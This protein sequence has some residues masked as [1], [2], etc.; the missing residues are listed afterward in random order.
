M[1]RAGAG[2]DLMRISAIDIGTNT[3]LMLIAEMADGG[4][5]RVIRDEHVIARLGK[6][7]DENRRIPPDAFERVLNHL[8]EYKRIH[9]SEHSGAIIACGTSALRDALN[10]DEFIVFIRERL[11]I[12]I[13][14]LSGEEEAALTYLGAVSEFAESEP[15]KQIV[16]I[17]IGGG[18]TEFIVGQGDAIRSRVSLDVG[19]V[20]LTERFLKNSPPLP[21]GL[22]EAQQYIRERVG[23]L[24][25]LSGKTRCIGVAGTLTTLAALD[26]QLSV[27]DRSRVSGH[28]L[29]LEVI[30]SIFDQLKRK[31]LE[32]LKAIPQILPQRADIILAG[33]LILQEFMGHLGMDRITASDRGLRYGIAL[34]EMEN[35]RNDRRN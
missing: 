31:R 1:G 22:A 35:Y 29:T 33:I 15:Q 26:L 25:Q 34:R 11:G 18:S 21:E 9:E 19:S 13:V 16:V 3:I 4:E 20:R 17:D 7:V 14:V 24:P 5:L 27:Y 12:E 32:E 10:R 6:G 23:G 30:Q 28:V 2:K 8:S